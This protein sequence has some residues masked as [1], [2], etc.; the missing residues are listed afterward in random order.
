MYR[1]VAAAFAAIVTAAFPAVGEA[2]VPVERMTIPDP[3]GQPLEVGIWAP[4]NSAS[5]LP[6][7]VMSHGS[8]GDF[9]SHEDTA[10][11]LA[12][13]GFVVAAIPRRPDYRV[14]ANAGHFDFLSPCAR[15]LGQHRPEI[16]AS[17]SGFDRTAFHEKLNRAAVSFFL[18]S[19]PSGPAAK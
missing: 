18:K 7:V 17:R 15:A 19:L 4:E 10:E 5:G 12:E 13:N 6:L 1:I 14:A 8:G 16:C 11:A 3:K 2:A 9:R